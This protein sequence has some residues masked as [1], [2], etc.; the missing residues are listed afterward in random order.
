MTLDECQQVLSSIRQRQG[1]E[2][3][4]LRIDLGG[5]VFL[6][7]LRRSDSDPEFRERR[8]NRYGSIVVEPNPPLAGTP[9]TLQIADLSWSAIKGLGDED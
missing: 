2:H 6:G 9:M 1:T 5:S 4:L 3:P 7:R 8:P